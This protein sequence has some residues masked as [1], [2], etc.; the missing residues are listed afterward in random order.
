[1]RRG[2]QAP[3]TPARARS[4]AAIAAGVV[5]A[6]RRRGPGWRRSPPSGMPASRSRAW[7]YSASST[8][9][10]SGASTSRNADV[11]ARA[12]ARRSA[13]GAREEAAQHLLEVDQERARRRRGT[14]CRPAWPAGAPPARRPSAAAATR[15]A[16]P[17]SARAREPLDR[18]A[19]DRGR[20]ARW[21]R[22]GS[23]ARSRS[24]ACRARRDRTAR[25]AR[26][27]AAPASPRTPATR[28]AWW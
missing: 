15:T 17:P 8:A 12:A 4:A 3:P 16:W 5:E 6:G 26:S 22:P 11:R 23:R 20:D 14:G 9:A 24:A 7:K 10:T 21:A 19:G 27:R 13:C 2:R 28:S 25:S 18:G 1:M